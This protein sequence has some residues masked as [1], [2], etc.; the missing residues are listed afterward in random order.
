MI[1]IPLH[2]QLGKLG[3]QLLSQSITTGNSIRGIH[4]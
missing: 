1:V 4:I 3:Y 2:A